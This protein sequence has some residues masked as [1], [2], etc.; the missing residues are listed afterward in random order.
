MPFSRAF[1]RPGLAFPSRGGCSQRR[2][3]GLWPWQLCPDGGSSSHCGSAEWL[4]VARSPFSFWP[5]SVALSGPSGQL[6]SIPLQAARL[7]LQLALLASFLWLHPPEAC[8][9][10]GVQRG[11]QFSRR[12]AGRVGELL[13]RRRFCPAVARSAMCGDG[14]WCADPF[15]SRLSSSA[16]KANATADGRRSILWRSRGTIS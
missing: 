15:D 2:E 9:S 8:W 10:L 11:G 3:L 13:V 12:E 6:A 7:R 1:R 16:C 14:A 5:A 4:K